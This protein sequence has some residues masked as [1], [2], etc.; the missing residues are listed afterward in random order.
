MSTQEALHRYLEHPF[1][2]GTAVHR[3]LQPHAVGQKDLEDM[4][5]TLD[6]INYILGG[7]SG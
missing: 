7:V 6:M 2:E 3:S 1:A 5:E 4:F